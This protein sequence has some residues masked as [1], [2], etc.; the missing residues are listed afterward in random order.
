MLRIA[1]STLLGLVLALPVT[2][3]AAERSDSTPVEVAAV[4]ATDSTR[5]APA[6]QQIT[7][8][9][10]SESALESAREVRGAR[11]SDPGTRF[12]NPYAFPLQTLPISLP[13]FS[14]LSF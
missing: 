1:S 11:Q 5:T 8:T 14:S 13:N 7:Q 6:V 12:N 9:Q 10:K 4:V 3:S 2:A